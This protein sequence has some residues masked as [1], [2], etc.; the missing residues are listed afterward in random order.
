[1]KKQTGKYIVEE[2][3]VLRKR[4]NLSVQEACKKLGVHYTTYYTQ[5]RAARRSVGASNDA[6]FLRRENAILRDQV[7]LYRRK[8]GEN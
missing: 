2:V 4:D 1:M 3:D 7:E 8:L 5:K 6:D